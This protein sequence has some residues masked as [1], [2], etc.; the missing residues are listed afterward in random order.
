MEVRKSYN[1]LISN[2]EEQYMNIVSK[3][4]VLLSQLRADVENIAL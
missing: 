3:S 1:A 4:D 2:T